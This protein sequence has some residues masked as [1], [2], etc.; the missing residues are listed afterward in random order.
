MNT[1][2][3]DVAAAKAEYKEQLQQELLRQAGVTV[4]SLRGSKNEVYRAGVSLEVEGLPGPRVLWK[5]HD[6]S[7]LPYSTCLTEDGQLVRTSLRRQGWLL[8]G[9]TWSPYQIVDIARLDAVEC[10]WLIGQLEDVRSHS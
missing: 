2:G 7:L 9:D 3:D 8:G 6:S 10:H 4:E 5:V 1:E